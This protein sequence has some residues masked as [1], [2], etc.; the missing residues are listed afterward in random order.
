MLKRPAAL[1]SDAGDRIMSF[2]V[3][4]LLGLALLLGGVSPARADEDSARSRLE[5]KGLMRIGSYHVLPDE[6]ELAKG[7]KTLTPLRREME[8]AIKLKA[9]YDEAV[10]ETRNMLQD[11][12]AQRRRLVVMLL[13]TR[14]DAEAAAVGLRLLEVSDRISQLTRQLDD[15]PREQAIRQRMDAASDAYCE[16]LFDLSAL[17]ERTQQRYEELADDEEVQAALDELRRETGR[18]ISLGPRKIFLRQVKELAELTDAIQVDRIDLRKRAEVFLIRVR[19]NGSESTDMILDTG[20]SFV[21]LPAALAAQVGIEPTKE[22]P[23]I[24]MHLADGQS[25]EG[26]LMSLDS[27]AV[28]KFHIEEVDCVVM[29]AELENAPALLGGS[30]LHHFTYKVDPGAGRLTLSR[31][32]LPSEE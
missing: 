12:V 13:R 1:V 25:V 4:I 29:P 32:G 8:A 24:S 21:V 18:R 9:R 17:V 23:S 27:V 10:A 31:I 3:R 15:K 20:A 2:P 5:Q 28:G 6:K 14:S 26:K 30:F 7:L 16:A 22:D 19:L 11:A